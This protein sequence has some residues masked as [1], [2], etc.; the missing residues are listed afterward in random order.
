MIPSLRVVL[1]KTIAAMIGQRLSNVS[2]PFFGAK[3]NAALSL[4]TQI[5]PSSGT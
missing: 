5:A 4:L 3:V 2:I 1:P